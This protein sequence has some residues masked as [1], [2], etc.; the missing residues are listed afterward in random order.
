LEQQH[1]LQQEQARQGAAQENQRETGTRLA[2]EIAALRERSGKAG[3]EVQ[4]VQT[5][6]A[7]VGESI[8]A[9]RTSRAT[10]EAEVVRVRATR[11]EV[12]ETLA[13]MRDERVE[14]EKQLAVLRAEVALDQ[15]ET[16]RVVLGERLLGDISRFLDIEPGWERACEAA[17]YDV[18]DFVVAAGE[19]DPGW[20][21]QLGTARPELRFGILTG[22]DVA[23]GDAPGIEHAAVI[24]RLS[25]HVKVKDGAPAGL[26]AMVAG[27]LVC[28]R[29]ES[30]ASCRV[31]LALVTRDGACRFP[32]GRVVL[33]SVERGRLSVGRMIADKSARVGEIDVESTRLAAEETRLGAVRDELDAQL[34]ATELGLF[35]S[36]RE[37]SSLDATLAAAAVAHDELGRDVERVQAE[38]QAVQAARRTTD[39]KLAATTAALAELATR[40]AATGESLKRAE[41]ETAAAEQIVKTNLEGSTAALAEQAEARQ[42]VARLESENAFAKRQIDESR[43]RINAF[44][45]GVTE[46]RGVA[47]Q[48]AAEITSRGG[49]ID[50]ARQVLVEFEAEI[51]KLAIA[52][53]ARAEEAL[54]SNLDELRAAQGTSQTLLM[55]QRMKL[56]ETNQKA[57]AMEEE[58]RTSYGADI[59]TFVPEAAPEAPERLAQLRRRLEALGQVNPLAGEEFAREKGDLERLRTQRQDVA[60]AKLNLEATLVEIDRHAQEQFVT[61]YAEVRGH[62]R[63]IF[64]ELFLEGEADL[65][66]MNDANPL[67]SEIAIIAKPRGKTPKRLEQLSDGEKALLAVS[68]L[69]AFYR[70]KPAPFCFLDEVDAPLDD[71]N[72]GRFADYLR[73]IAH[74][75]QVMIITHNRLTVE[76]AD[77]V[78]GVTAEQP[79]V[80]KLVS[81]SLAEYKQ[82]QIPA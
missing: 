16:G 11:A 70:V 14:L 5:K 26:A 69:F 53:I 24:G 74:Q 75:T 43:H 58:A 13:R 32:D 67:E 18:L 59:A 9:A 4:V 72:V 71:A 29:A 8:G 56:Y 15:L 37:K 51:E 38:Y 55:E 35:E 1:V 3:G 10:L 54:E 45:R 34:S 46:G 73:G 33:A 66:L 44:E 30:F 76:R 57:Q 64:R 78:F 41:A 63:E 62:F 68:L 25:D 19:F 42:A 61:T 39:E 50:A 82:Q 31:K 40:T 49:E 2:A 80:S 23:A 22:A 7:A 6:L 17:L 65:V 79:G 20:L 81:V 48:L 60:Q 12:R 52:D 77:V 47:E 28:D 36:E 21:A 27:V